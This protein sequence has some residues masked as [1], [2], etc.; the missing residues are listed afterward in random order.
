M[1]KQYQPKSIEHKWLSF[2]E[3]FQAP[4]QE[5]PSFS[6][7]LPPP[8]VTGVLHMGHLLAYTL[9]DFLVRQKRMEGFR[10]LFLPGTDHAGIATQS[11]VEQ[12]LYKRTG[13]TRED[14]SRE[15]FLSEIW[16]FKEEKQR[17]ILQ[18]LK[19]TGASLDWSRLRFTLDEQSSKAVTICFKKLFDEGLI[20]RGD[21][22]VNWDP[23]LQTALSD[24]EVEYE[25]E[26]SHLWYIRYPIEKSEDHLVVATT[27]P[28]TLL[29]DAA[30]AVHPEDARFQ[31]LIGKSVRL[32]LQNR[33]IPII[34]DSYVDPLFG[35][36]C[37]KITPAH[38]ENDHQ[39]GRA[40][41]LS[42]INIMTKAGTINE[43]GAPFTGLSMQEARKSVLEA[44]RK[45]NLLEKTEP[46]TL[47]VGRSYRSKAKIEPYLSKQWF[48]RM[49]PFKKG[50]ID[51]VK[52]GEVTLFPKSREQTYLHWI[53]NLRDW[54]IS[55]QLVWGHPIPI[56]HS[57]SDPDAFLCADEEG[58]PEEV[59]KNPE[60]WEQDPDVLDTWFSSALWPLSTL[61]WPESTQDLKDFYPTSILVTGHDILFFWVARMIMMGKYLTGKA[62]FHRAF[63][64]GLI[65]GK[66]YWREEGGMQAYLSEDERRLYDQGE[67]A[68]PPDIHSKWEKMSK[69]KGNVIDPLEV[70]EQYG[71][72][73]IRLSLLSSMNSSGQI[74]LDTRRFQEQ[75]NFINKIWNSARFVFGSID[76]LKIKKGIDPDLLTLEDH[77]ILLKVNELI[78][79]VEGYIENCSLEK[80]AQELYNF[81]WKT[82]CSLYIETSKPYLRQESPKDVRQNKQTLLAIL[83]NCLIRLLHPAIPF[84]TEEIFQTL[85]KRFSLLPKTTCP[86]LEDLRISLEKE[87]CIVAPYPKPL[88]VPYLDESATAKMQFLQEI[89]YQL[90]NIRGDMNIPS[91]EKIDLWVEI[92]DL[93]LSM[94]DPLWTILPALVPLG[95]I[96][97]KE[98]PT[99][100]F[101]AAFATPSATFF[102]PL[103]DQLLAKEKKRW[104]KEEEKA[105][106]L[107]KRLTEKLRNPQFLENAPRKIVEEHQEMLK[108]VHVSLEEIEKKRKQW[109]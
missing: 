70:I 71:T 4:K 35:S 29:G 95:K 28:E 34:A 93:S 57:K 83:L 66:S 109:L 40:H 21:Y 60:N 100:S 45:E 53:E 2:W 17:K 20:Y 64:H 98:R 39:I 67:K 65:Y 10:A 50:L 85:K 25:E 84:I 48:I 107:Q 30:V 106:S 14:F 3:R 88:Q 1:D 89:V 52:N 74:D 11:V 36:G 61:G 99:E 37:V 78:E 12:M 7:I 73:A 108:K 68:L 81:Y 62:P 72:D 42:Q 91:R 56:W 15:E 79:K 58:I 94:E 49:E 8:N 23:H 24:D 38:D 22:L 92:T 77:A 54:C 87:G 51:V 19:Q 46:H 105:R 75:R 96:E 44:L 86:Y 13:K 31:S 104:D 69:S 27:R 47:R 103:S 82:F 26:S 5:G 97:A 101:G 80:S 41:G 76:D 16:S 63:V 90:R 6:V 43:K 32:P 102:V 59:Q 18:Q 33:L 55:R 9:Q